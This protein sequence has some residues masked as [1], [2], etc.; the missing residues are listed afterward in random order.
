MAE[1]AVLLG[2][3]ISANESLKRLKVRLSDVYHQS[4]HIYYTCS[5]LY[6]YNILHQKPNDTFS[7]Y[8]ISCELRYYRES[9][10]FSLLLND[11]L[12]VIIC[13]Q[14]GKNPMQSAG[15]YAICAAI[16]RNPNSAMEELD[17]TVSWLLNN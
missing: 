11:L 6:L 16:T 3:G 10:D 14:I 17:F 12:F 1:G 13:L 4:Y 2:K 7:N 15:C 8:E 9:N 5:Y